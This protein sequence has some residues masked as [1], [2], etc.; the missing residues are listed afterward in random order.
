LLPTV[1]SYGE[2]PPK[3]ISPLVEKEASYTNARAPA[4]P[5][6]EHALNVC[7]QTH[8]GHSAADFVLNPSRDEVQAG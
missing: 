5:R 3:A 1:R 8:R 7:F 2:V 4:F 6:P